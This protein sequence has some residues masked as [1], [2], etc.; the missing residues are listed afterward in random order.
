M[1]DNDRQKDFFWGA[2]VG[3]AVATLTTLLFTTKKG[4]EVQDRIESTYNEIE[5]AISNKM[6]ESKEKLEEGAE[7][8]HKKVAHALKHPEDHTRSKQEEAHKHSK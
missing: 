4:K 1:Y 7:S 5:K 6:A 2:F 8:A 3:G